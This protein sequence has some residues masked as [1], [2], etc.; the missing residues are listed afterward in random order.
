M[1]LKK[2]PTTTIINTPYGKIKQIGLVLWALVFT[3]TLSAQDVY[4]AGYDNYGSSDIAQIWE[5]DGTTEN[6]TSG[7]E[8]ARATDIFI[9]EGD[10]Y[11]SGYED[12]GNHYVAKIWKNGTPQDLTDGSQRAY[13]QS[14]FVA[15]GDV[16]VAGYEDNGT[17]DV[18]KLWKNGNPQNLT[19]GSQ[20]AHAESVFVADGNVYVIGTEY[21]YSVDGNYVDAVAKIWKNGTAQDLTDGTNYAYIESVF[22]NN[23]DVYAAGRESNGTNY[24]AKLWK[25]GNPQNLTDG[26][27]RA[28]ANSVFINNGDVYVVGYDGDD[29]MLWKNGVGEILNTNSAFDGARAY[30]VYV[31]GN[32]VYVA[33]TSSASNGSQNCSFATFWKNGYIDFISQ[34]CP[35]NT[36][37]YSVVVDDGQ[38]G[39]DTV[40]G[41]QNNLA[42]YPNP[43]QDVLYINV[44]EPTGLQLYNLQGQLLQEIEAGQNTQINMSG[45]A[46]G[47]YFIKDL[48]GGTSHKVVKE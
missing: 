16:Y 46:A 27:S 7:N 42:L 29:P 13:A 12:D 39:V 22:V 10:Q 26:S 47:V 48:N 33:G 43:V 1:K 31:S 19:D 11:V 9:Y 21:D 2:Y 17:N 34:A 4:V 15:D 32:D 18:A 6:L 20:N 8:T 45:L 30:S 36:A 41:L 24:I 5:G 25:N 44:Q 23:G 37:M 28:S 38:L 35:D 40:S 14:V 3:I